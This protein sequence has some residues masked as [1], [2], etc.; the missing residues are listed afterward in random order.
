[1]LD[2]L[3]EL[4]VTLDAPPELD[5]VMLKCPELGRLI[6]IHIDRPVLHTEDDASPL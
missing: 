2:G 6:R 5:E 3:K 4:H 1:V